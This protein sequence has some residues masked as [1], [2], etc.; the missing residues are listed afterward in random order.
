MDYEV[1]CLDVTPLRDGNS[2]AEFVAVGLWT[3]ISVRILRL[4]NFEEVTK[5]PLGGGKFFF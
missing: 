3:D 4:P 1:A 2:R 5:E